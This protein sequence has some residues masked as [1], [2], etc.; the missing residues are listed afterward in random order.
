M[1]CI[2]T[3]LHKVERTLFSGVYFKKKLAKKKKGFLWMLVLIIH[4]TFLFYQSGRSGINIDACPGSMDLFNRIRPR[5]TNLEIGIGE[6]EQVLN[7]YF[8]DKNSTINS[9]SRRFLEKMNFST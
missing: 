1:T 2:P 7:Y 4:I 5:D 8:V 3:I 6:K 9:F